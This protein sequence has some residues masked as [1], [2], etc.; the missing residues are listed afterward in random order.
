MLVYVLVYPMWNWK[1]NTIA[2]VLGIAA[3]SLCQQSTRLVPLNW[4]VLRS[5]KSNVEF[6]FSAG[7]ISG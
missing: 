6:T 3:R 1:V 7:A 5:A 2:N 4:V